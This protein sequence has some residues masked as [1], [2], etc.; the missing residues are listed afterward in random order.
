M[1]DHQNSDN[2][3]LPDIEEM[4]S[5]QHDQT[6]LAEHKKNQVSRAE[7]KTAPIDG[8]NVDLH[9]F[10]DENASLPSIHE[11]SDLEDVRVHNKGPKKNA[12]DVKDA[13]NVADEEPA[14]ADD[15][16]YDVEPPNIP[17][18]IATRGGFIDEI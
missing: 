18:G 6:E 15:N 5:P 9:F 7:F 8:S 3:S 13:K 17:E 14:P 1:E 10:E 2:D 12:K 11:E 4:E 16:V